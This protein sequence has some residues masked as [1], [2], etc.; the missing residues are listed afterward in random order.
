LA[1]VGDEEVVVVDVAGVVVNEGVDEA[2]GEVEEA[3][4]LVCGGVAMR[5]CAGADAGSGEYSWVSSAC[6][7]ERVSAVI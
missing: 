1:N 3:A 4:M 6:I 7:C 2:V 5:V